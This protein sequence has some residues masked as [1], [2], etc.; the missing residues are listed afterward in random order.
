MTNND[1]NW[2]LICV[3]NNKYEQ[4]TH[5]YRHDKFRK[6]IIVSIKR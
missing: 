2:V 5:A 1:N 4:Q 3:D 6:L